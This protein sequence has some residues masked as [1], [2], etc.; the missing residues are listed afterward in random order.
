MC[1]LCF[2]VA[3][4]CLWRSLVLPIQDRRLPEKLSFAE[5]SLRY[6]FR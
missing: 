5:T 2:Q 1:S 6:V 4:C 3:F